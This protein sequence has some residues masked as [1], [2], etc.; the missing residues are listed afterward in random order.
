MEENSTPKLKT[1]NFP[2]P[3]LMPHPHAN[4][5]NLTVQDGPLI[6]NLCMFQVGVFDGG[7]RSQAQ[8][9]LE[10][11]DGEGA[12]AHTPSPTTTSLYVGRLSLGTALVAMLLV[13][14]TWGGK[15]WNEAGASSSLT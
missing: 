14:Q 5:I 8:D 7:G 9:L 2:K 13:G 12:L 11:L 4:H 3:V 10:K 6:V 15:T 1:V